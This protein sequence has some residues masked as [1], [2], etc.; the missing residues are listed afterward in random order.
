MYPMELLSDC[1]KSVTQIKSL[2]LGLGNTNNIE[3]RKV[4]SFIGGQTV[5]GYFTN[6]KNRSQSKEAS[7]YSGY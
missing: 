4:T 5:S 2:K 6:E 7:K 3:E 1:V